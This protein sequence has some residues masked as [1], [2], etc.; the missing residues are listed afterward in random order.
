MVKEK[1]KV[2]NNTEEFEIQVEK[3]KPVSKPTSKGLES[4]NTNQSLQ[5]GQNE[6]SLFEVLQSFYKY[7]LKYFFYS[8]IEK[9]IFKSI[10]RLNL[11]ATIFFKGMWL[12]IYC[13]LN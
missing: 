11:L 13:K 1:D 7:N 9:C 5:L 8:F 10:K 6:S 12:Y 4:I 2:D 3:P